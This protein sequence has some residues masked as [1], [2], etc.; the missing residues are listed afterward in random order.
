MLLLLSIPKETPKKRFFA[1]CAGKSQIAVCQVAKKN[2]GTCILVFTCEFFEKLGHSLG[3]LWLSRMSSFCLRLKSR[4]SILSFCN[5]FLF[6]TMLASRVE[7][8]VVENEQSLYELTTLHRL[9]H[10]G[11][12]LKSSRKDM[13]WCTNSHRNV[14]QLS[15][16]WLQLLTHLLN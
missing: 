4:W 8:M 16:L 6:S 14:T 3:L 2:N 11:C 12:C 5:T 9:Q 13:Y 1:V 10:K 15:W 7:D